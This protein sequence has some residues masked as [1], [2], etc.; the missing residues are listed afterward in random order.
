MQGS[1]GV[2]GEK[3]EMREDGGGAEYGLGE[4][5]KQELWYYF[6]DDRATSWSV[7]GNFGESKT[8]MTMDLG[9][10]ANLCQG[11]AGS[12]TD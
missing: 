11:L 3:Q 2:I 5:R 8:A 12:I 6:V 9:L 7:E 10:R 4:G 1:G